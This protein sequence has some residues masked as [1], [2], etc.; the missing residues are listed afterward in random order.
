MELVAPAAEPASDEAPH[1]N[2]RRK[3]P[4]RQLVGKEPRLKRALSSVAR[5][6]Y[7]CG[8]VIAARARTRN[9]LTSIPEPLLFTIPV[10]LFLRLTGARL[11]FIVHDP[12]P[13]AWVLPRPLI[14][15]ER[16]SLGVAYRLASQLVVLS[17]A[18]ARSLRAAF[19]V[20]ED[21]ISVIPIG[22]RPR[23]ATP[24][25]GNGRLL[26]F[27][28]IR[29]NK[30]IEE[31]IKGVLRAR[32][33]GVDVRLKIAGGASRE[34]PDYCQAI[35]TLVEAHPDV[36]EAEIGYIA[37]E[38]IPQIVAECDAF[39]LPYEGF[40]SQ[41]GVALLAGLMARPVISTAVGG[42]SSLYDLGL[43]GVTI[44]LPVTEES[45]AI[46]VK[47]FYEEPPE[48]WRSIA[49]AGR[50]ALMETL[51]WRVIARLY[52]QEFDFDLPNASLAA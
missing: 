37:E 9:F 41:S 36:I 40:E 35:R 8:Y 16:L 5:I 33:D 26:V 15:L 38:R 48:R 14:W 17:P 11:V 6:L 19:G 21:R 51:D 27:G 50:A 25:P 49:D 52:V 12:N 30:R 3:V 23:A 43:S 39:L 22:A 7:G 4:P 44:G 47:K 31:S 46:A 34:E 20:N 1:A 2:L 32:A 42:L 28:S 10:F 13:H 18:T 24:L 29:S 45:V